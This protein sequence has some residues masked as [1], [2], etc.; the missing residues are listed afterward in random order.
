MAIKLYNDKDELTIKLNS[1]AVALMI[2]ASSITSTLEHINAR[3]ANFQNNLFVLGMVCIVVFASIL[4]SGKVRIA[5][6][7]LSISGLLIIM[8]VYTMI[9]FKSYSAISPIQFIFYAIVPV[10]VISQRLDGELVM[11]YSLY[12]SMLTATCINEMFRI[13]YTSVSQ[14]FMGNIYAVLSPVLIAMI[15]FRLYRKQSNIVTKIAYLYNLYVMFLIF[16]YANRGA[17]VCIIFCLA[18]LLING[19][20]ESEERKKLSAIK[21]IL[22][23]IFSSAAIFTV[24]NLL[25]VL[26]MARDFMNDVFHSVPSFISKMIYYI[27]K[28]DVTD[29]RAD[30]NVYVYSAIAEKPIFGHGI[31]TFQAFATEQVGRTWPYVHQYIL[32]YLFEGGIVFGLIPI[33]LSLILTAKVLCTMISTKKEFAICATLVCCVIPRYLLSNEPWLST[34]IW[35]LITYSLINIMETH[36]ISQLKLNHS[37]YS[38]EN[39]DNAV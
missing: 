37:H 6:P 3:L 17:V 38:K 25:A 32:Q 31:K 7:F 20:T 30:I 8:Y 34:T 13:Q 27:N 28:G 29:G 24:M 36:N 9:F 26:E 11:R 5:I 22:I 39:I 2:A 10:Y 23:I 15:H 21:I 1:L 14:A 33:A 12:I 35:M 19:Y 18:V 16:K 4:N